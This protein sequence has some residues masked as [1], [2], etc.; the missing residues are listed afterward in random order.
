MISLSDYVRPSSF[1]TAQSSFISIDAQLD[2][3]LLS[4][5]GYC[6][7][8]PRWYAGRHSLGRWWAVRCQELH[9]GCGLRLRPEATFCPFCPRGP[10]SNRFPSTTVLLDLNVSRFLASIYYSGGCCT[11]LHEQPFTRSE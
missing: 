3:C 4:R 9:E 5:R 7:S 2:A 6:I 10:I 8:A 11:V 1:S